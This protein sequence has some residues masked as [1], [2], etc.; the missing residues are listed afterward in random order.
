MN[1]TVT[2]HSRQLWNCCEQPIMHK[3]FRPSEKHTAHLLRYTWEINCKLLVAGDTLHTSGGNA[4]QT[5]KEISDA[6]MVTYIPNGTVCGW[7]RCDKTPLRDCGHGQP[8]SCQG[9]PW[10]IIVE[11]SR[12]KLTDVK[13]SRNKQLA[14]VITHNPSLLRQSIPQ[15][16]KWGL[17]SVTR[18]KIRVKIREIETRK[19]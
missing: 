16:R 15:W 12:G 2:S 14:Q 18:V 4:G 19:G 5:L 6:E 3:I 13:I 8:T 11:S 10:G 17:V 7:P 9:Y 1:M